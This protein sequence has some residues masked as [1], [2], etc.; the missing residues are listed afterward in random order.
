MI[1]L[2]EAFHYRCEGLNLSL[3][4]SGA[5]FVTLIVS[6]CCHRASKYHATFSPGSGKYG[7]SLP[8]RQ[9]QLM[10]SKIVNKSH[11]T[12]MLEI[13]TVKQKQRKP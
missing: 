4:G 12:H 7:L 10:M 11:S 9:C 3:L 8:H 6:C 2:A 1:L 13:I 5:R